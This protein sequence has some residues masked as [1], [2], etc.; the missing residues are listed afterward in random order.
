MEEGRRFL[1]DDIFFENI[2][3]YKKSPE[4][5]RIFYVYPC[6]KPNFVPAPLRFGAQI[7]MLQSVAKPGDH[8]S[9]NCIAA[10]L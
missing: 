5:Q 8:F 9:T 10:I 2:I 7:I 6:D 4:F 1:F 3:T